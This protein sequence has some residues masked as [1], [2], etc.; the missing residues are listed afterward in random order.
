MLPHL[1]QKLR[2]GVG[3]GIEDTGW[4]QSLTTSLLWWGDHC[5]EPCGIKNLIPASK[6]TSK[7]YPHRKL[8]QKLMLINLIKLTC[9]ET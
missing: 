2:V 6:L 1:T 7:S 3:S 5:P 4:P 8:H 9:S